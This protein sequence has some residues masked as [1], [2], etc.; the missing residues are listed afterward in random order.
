MM[1]STMDYRDR[2]EFCVRC[3]SEVQDGMVRCPS[4]GSDPHKSRN[5]RY[6]RWV[7]VLIPIALL[8]LVQQR[9]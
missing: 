8:I 5:D 3:G 7:E 4:C 2:M 1:G 9:G 6:Y